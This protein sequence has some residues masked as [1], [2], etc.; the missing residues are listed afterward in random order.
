MSTV[1]DTAP[2]NALQPLYDGADY[3]KQNVAKPGWELIV[4]VTTV[5]SG[6]KND[7]SGFLKSC[8]T[9]LA[10]YQAYRHFS[11]T[12]VNPKFEKVMDAAN[13][14]YGMS[15]FKIFNTLFGT[16]NK[17]TISQGT[18]NNIKTEVEAALTRS[19][20]SQQDVQKKTGEIV[21]KL[22][23]SG[24]GYY[25]EETLKETLTNYLVDM[26]KISE[27]DAQQA[28]SNIN[29]SFK[30]IDAY[31]VVKFIQTVAFT[32]VDVEVVTI[33]LREWGLV[34]VS[35]W[36]ETIGQY[37]VF[38]FV[39]SITLE[40]VCRVTCI[41]GYSASIVLAIMDI[42]NAYLEEKTV[43]NT[44]ANEQKFKNLHKQ[45]VNGA[46]D[47]ATNSF[48]IVLNTVGLFQIDK[49]AFLVLTIATKGFGV[50]S[51]FYKLWNK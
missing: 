15:I 8:Q 4:K 29:V 41:V 46:I 44:P 2:A 7:E 45:K 21:K 19:G 36:A 50:I 25:S 26:A 13:I 31:S 11:G 49:G 9:I 3:L 35:G 14:Q 18:F 34:D 37:S 43:A 17:D 28:T 48:D 39:Q 30:R 5:F 23:D 47:I 1:N 42:T 24:W 16:V 6:V 51:V 38:S 10:C 20:L 40:S 27:A 12:P 33:Y 22:L 32:A